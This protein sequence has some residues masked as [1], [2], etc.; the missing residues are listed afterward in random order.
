[1]S[2]RIHI[3][4]PKSVSTKELFEMIYASKPE[5]KCILC[6][7]IGKYT[8]WESLCN[9]NCYYSLNDLFSSFENG[10]VDRPDARV[11]DY[12]TRY[13]NPTHS[14]NDDKVRMWMGR[15]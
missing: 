2:R 8:G 1:M 10:F 14:F 7:K 6:G 9:R 13:P 4:I 5:Q 12:Y 11:I 15:N 3:T